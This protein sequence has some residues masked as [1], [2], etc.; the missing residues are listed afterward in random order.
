MPSMK[1]VPH[2]DN[3][4]K[5]FIQH[6]MSAYYGCKVACWDKRAFS[7]ERQFHSSCCLSPAGKPHC[8]S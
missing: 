6:E 2:H 5:V 1:T 8:R 3:T 4:G 7:T